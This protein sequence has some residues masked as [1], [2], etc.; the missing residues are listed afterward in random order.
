MRIFAVDR[1]NDLY[2]G[3]DKHLAINS[4]LEALM[5]TAQ[6]VMQSIL[7]EMVHAST[8]GLPYRETVWCS[9]PNL[10]LFE[11]NARRSLSGIKGVLAVESFSCTVTE[12]ILRYWATLRTAYGQGQLNG[13]EKNNA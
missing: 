7:G 6:H 5:Q 4:D 10:R 2:L 1:N 12:N 11:D 3:P 9:A 8:R 13:E